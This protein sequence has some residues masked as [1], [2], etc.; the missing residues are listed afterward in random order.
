MAVAG[1]GGGESVGEGRGREKDKGTRMGAVFE[2]EKRELA[3]GLFSRD[4]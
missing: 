2:A 3:D 4:S 1:V